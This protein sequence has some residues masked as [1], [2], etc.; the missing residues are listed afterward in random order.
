MFS[1]AW[2]ESPYSEARLRGMGG[3]L[4]KSWKEA[5]TTIGLEASGEA[6]AGGNDAR[7]S[8]R[9]QHYRGQGLLSIH[10]EQR[11][12]GS[13]IGNGVAGFES[14]TKNCQPLIHLFH[15]THITCVRAV[16]TAVVCCR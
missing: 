16:M 5:H 11:S 14:S 8:Q 12:S 1:K 7:S 3:R 9:E 6:G 15:F 13:S 2:T 10:Q 4:Q